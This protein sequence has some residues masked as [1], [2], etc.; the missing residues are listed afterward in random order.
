MRSADDWTARK[1]RPGSRRLLVARSPH[2][3]EKKNVRCNSNAALNFWREGRRQVGCALVDRLVPVTERQL[4]GPAQPTA[5][6]IG[7]GARRFCL[8]DRALPASTGSVAFQSIG[9]SKGA[10]TSID[11]E[12]ATRGTV[13]A[14]QLGPHSHAPD[15]LAC[16]SH[17]YLTLAQL[18]H[19]RTHTGTTKG[20]Q[21]GPFQGR[22]EPSQLQRG[23]GARAPAMA[24]VYDAAGS[25][26]SLPYARSFVA[27]TYRGSP[28][29]Y[30]SNGRP[31]IGQGF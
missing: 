28:A 10:H 26:P 11:S 24:D 31:L 15:P 16:L 7:T 18:T 9:C 4:S 27:C 12:A 30:V 23:K 25:T 20:G 17:V 3:P 5:P 6:S 14:G 19:P 29:P 21:V 22:R 13:P 2:T 1:R 8:D